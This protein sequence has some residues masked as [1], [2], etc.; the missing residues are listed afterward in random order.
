MPFVENTGLLVKRGMTGA[1]GNIYVGLQEFEDMGF[2]LHFLNKEDLFVDIGA[3]IGSYTVLA[4]GVCKAYTISIEPISSTYRSLI[5]NIAINNLENLTEPYQLAIG[6]NAS[7][8]EMT[9]NRDTTNHI[10]EIT[11]N[12]E[13]DKIL[14]NSN[15]L[16]N[17]INKR[18]VSC[19]KIDVEGFENEVLAG[20]KHTL[21]QE[22]LQAII[23]EINGNC[24]R[25]GVSEDQ[26]HNKLVQYNFQPYSYNPLNRQLTRLSTHR[27]EGNTLYIK[28][29]EEVM[30]RIRKASSVKVFN[31]IF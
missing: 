24:N 29:F 11:D 22:S 31:T 10:V 16:D 27:V 28:N 1:T 14:V 26:I 5:Q 30:N 6:E 15:S 12:I 21:F 8:L 13:S 19:L 17:L 2:L 9:S 25:Y 7:V 18:S 3:N 23:I 20:A 4:A